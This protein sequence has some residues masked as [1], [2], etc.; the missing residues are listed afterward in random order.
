MINGYM[1]VSMHLGDEC[2]PG[3]KSA[4]L[5]YSRLP[6]ADCR[7]P[8][9]FRPLIWFRFAIPPP[10]RQTGHWLGK[11]RVGG[12]WALGWSGPLGVW[13]AGWLGAGSLSLAACTLLARLLA[14]SRCDAQFKVIIVT[15]RVFVIAAFSTTGSEYTV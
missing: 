4:T 13:L 7:N 12:H 10:S 14:D 8:A 3:G 11:A 15:T 5:P 1:Y 2:I 9:K 6:Q